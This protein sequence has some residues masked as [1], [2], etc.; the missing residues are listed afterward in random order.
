MKLTEAKL[1]QMILEALRDSSFRS[2]GIPTPDEKL[3]SD[4]GGEM[5]DKIQ[6]LDPEQADIMKQSFDPGYPMDL[7][8]ESLDAM[9]T[10][11]GF[12]F[13]DVSKFTKATT[14]H[15]NYSSRSWFKGRALGMGS[16][17]IKVDYQIYEPK[18]KPGTRILRYDV[19]HRKKTR[20]GNAYGLTARG[21]IEI[22]PM[23]ELSLKTKQGLEQADAL[24]V[25][26]ENEEIEKTL[27]EY[28]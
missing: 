5:F 13:Y 9:L 12:E 28:K 18:R 6:G 11:A 22:P 20:Y 21:K 7:K 26:R 1:K 8:Q 3:R 2:F 15:D 14:M 27:E 10:S 23:F 24:M 17:E 4:L 16:I 19:T 25:S